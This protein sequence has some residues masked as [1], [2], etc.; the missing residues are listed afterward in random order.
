MQYNRNVTYE[1][2]EPEGCIVC[3]LKITPAKTVFSVSIFLLIIMFIYSLYNKGNNLTSNV[4]RGIWL[5][6]K[7]PGLWAL[8]TTFHFKV[9]TNLKYM[10]KK[11]ASYMKSCKKMINENHSS[12]GL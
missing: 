9:V 10:R 1:T 2:T 11:G 12:K 5:S 4:M 8:S 6:P 7:S 3:T